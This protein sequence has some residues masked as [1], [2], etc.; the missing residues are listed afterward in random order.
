MRVI[1][2]VPF[3]NE[4]DLWQLRYET[5]KDV[6]DEFVVVE[7]RHT[8]SGQRKDVCFHGHADPR[9]H[10]HC[11]H[12]H[13]VD[14]PEPALGE[15]TIPATRRREM[16]QRNA[17]T[18]AILEYI[19]RLE[20]DAI[21][22]VSDC[23]E[24][25]NPQV[26]A[27][28]RENGLPDGHVVICR[29]RFCYYDLN[30]SS[31]YI[32]QGTRAISWRDLRVL[33]PHVTRYGLGTPDAHYPRYVVAQPGGWHLS[34]FGGA[35]AVRTKIQSFLHQELN[36]PDTLRQVDE[37]IAAGEDVYGRESTAFVREATQD[38]PPPV[39]SD[40]DR[41]RHLYHEEYRDG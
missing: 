10:R 34:Y 25:P 30:T 8:H 13:V 27:Y 26:I 18:Q 41:W 5:L 3:F 14:L 21:V 29:Q 40:P 7:A 36:N 35:D 32:W 23:D 12:H 2:A 17:I 20:D 1:D 33:S 38:V 19:P 22:L 37:R 6:V 16:F 4:N 15:T 28:L 11:V 24:I 31:G 9:S 39:L